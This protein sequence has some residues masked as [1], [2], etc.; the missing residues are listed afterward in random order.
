MYAARLLGF[1]VAL[2]A[3]VATA[4]AATLD[5][6]SGQVWVDKGK[7]PQLVKGPVQVNPG[8]I[9]TVG[10]GSSARIAYSG[11]CFVGAA[12]GTVTTVTADGQCVVNGV[13]NNSLVGLAGSIA[14]G[15]TLVTIAVKERSAS[16]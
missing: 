14:I 3:L 13:E 5:S 4:S 10:P 1:L 6:I 8:D 11:G 15:A 16:P 2:G 7:G 9:V 12:A